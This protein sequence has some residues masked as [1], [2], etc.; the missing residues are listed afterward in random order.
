MQ[1]FALLVPRRKAAG[2]FRYLDHLRFD[3]G[4][5]R[6]WW[7]LVLK[8]TQE[9]HRLYTQSLHDVRDREVEAARRNWRRIE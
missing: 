2:P 9:G 1:S 8:G 4:N 3:L 5:E 6:G 7:R